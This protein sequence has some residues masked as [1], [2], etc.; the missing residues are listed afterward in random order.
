M[1]PKRR[2]GDKN[3]PGTIQ[4][5]FLKH[6]PRIILNFTHNLL[7]Q[8]KLREVRKGRRKMRSTSTQW[9][10]KPSNNYCILIRDPSSSRG[11]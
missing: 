9:T 1:Y 7:L 2:E 3:Q 11:R 5:T 8:N 4:K 10:I 6:T